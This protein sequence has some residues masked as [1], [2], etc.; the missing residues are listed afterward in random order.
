M[1]CFTSPLCG[2][3]LVQ[4]ESGGLKQRLRSAVNDAPLTEEQQLGLISEH[5]EVNPI[6]KATDILGK[7][8]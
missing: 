7:L 4:S 6:R 3:L 1:W 5:C 8:T 2:A